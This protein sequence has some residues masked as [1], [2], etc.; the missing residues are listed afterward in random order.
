MLS[1][2]FNSFEPFDSVLTPVCSLLVPWL[3]VDVPFFNTFDPA[4]NSVVPSVI[5]SNPDEIALIPIF[6]LDEACVFNVFNPAFTPFSF[7]VCNIVDVTV[8]GPSSNVK[9]TLLFSE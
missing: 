1:P 7:N 2:V 9:N 6:I 8:D 3:N 4:I 5:E